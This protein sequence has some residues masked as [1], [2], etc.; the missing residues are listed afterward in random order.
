MKIVEVKSKNGT[1]FMILDGNNEPI[2]DAVRYLKYL[3]SVKK[4]LNTKKTYAYALKNFFVYLESK[5]ICYKE[6]SFD[7]F[8][9]F[10]RWMKTPFEYENVLSYHR[11]EKSISPKTINLTMTVVSN[12]YDYLYRSKK[13]DVNFYDFMHMESKYSKKYKSFMHHINL[14]EANNIRD[15]FLIQLLYETGLRIGEVLSLRI[16]DI[17]FDF[18]KGHQIVLKNRF[19]DNGTYLKTGERK[20]FISQSLIDLYDDYVYEIID[21]LSICSDY[22]FVKIKGR[23]VGEA[24][25]YSDIYS[26]FKR[27]KHKTSINVHPHLFRHTH[28]TVFYNETKDIKQV[29]ERLG[30][31]NIQTTINLYVHPTEE[32]IREDWNKVKHQFQVF[33]KGE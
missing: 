24:M 21:E 27:L 29:Q 22:L 17:K 5:K 1:N 10:I 9:D 15:K 14:E 19:N 6:V 3:D 16:D 18:R 25:N 28:A 33:N 11:K 23:N 7:N 32:D 31:S 8:V 26:L 2:V 4:S 12:F 13:L 30:H 20:I